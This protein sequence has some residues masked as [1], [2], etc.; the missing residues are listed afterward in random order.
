MGF[1]TVKQSYLRYIE[2]E[3][4]ISFIVR[5][6]FWPEKSEVNFLVK[7]EKMGT[8]YP[9]TLSKGPNLNKPNLYPLTSFEILSLSPLH[10]SLFLS[11]F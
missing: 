6:Y 10:F 8:S 4:Y 7:E 1:M 3:E 2:K 11:H 5:A 9:R